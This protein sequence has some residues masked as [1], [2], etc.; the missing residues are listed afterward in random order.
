MRLI[1]LF[2]K[3]TFSRLYF[4]DAAGISLVAFHVKF[5]DEFVGLEAGTIARDITRVTNGSWT[6]YD[7]TTKLEKNDTIY[8]WIHVVYEGLGYN[9]VEQEYRVTGKFYTTK[10]FVMKHL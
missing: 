4:L 1:K 3:L 8:Y 9:L 7:G 5:N 6:Y 10:Y 2:L